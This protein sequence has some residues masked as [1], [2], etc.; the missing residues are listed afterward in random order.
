MSAVLTMLLAGN[1]MAGDGPRPKQPSL[2]RHVLPLLAK[3]GC[4]SGACHGA[5]Q[6]QNG[7]RL[8][9][10]GVDPEQDRTHLLR[11][12]GGRRVDLQNPDNSLF[13]RKALGQMAHE[14]GAR[15]RE[16]TWEHEL[17]R[18]WVQQGL[19]NDET[20]GSG[21]VRLQVTPASTT[22][23]PGETVQ[24]QVEATHADG[25]KEDVTALCTFET[26]V[27]DT[28]AALEGGR[29]EAVQPGLSAV[30]VR[31]GAEPVVAMV[32]VPRPGS[33][34]FP[35]VKGNNFIDEHV[36]A[37]LRR[38]NLPPSEVCDDAT[39]LRR[40]SLDATGTLPTPAEV[41]AFLAD[42][43][44]RK[45]E[46]KIAELLE[47]PGYSALWATKFCDL[48]KIS[49]FDGN[50]AMSEAAEAKRAYDWIRQR[51]KENV[52]YDHLV[53]RILTA[54]SRE[55]REQQE[56][57]KEV[58]RMAEENA[59]RETK[60]SAYL[61]RKTLDLYWQRKEATGIKG[62]LQAAHAFLGLRLECAQC[63]R[64][65][66]DVWKQDD[67]LSFANFFMR[68][69][70]AGYPNAKELNP[71]AAQRLKKAPMEAKALRA[72]VKKLQDRLKSLT[73]KGEKGAI[74]R[75]KEEIAALEVKARAIESGPKRY[76]TE[77]LHQS[78]RS[79]YAS[80]TSPLGTQRSEKFRLL[81]AGKESKPS[82]EQ[83][84]RALVMAWLR[85]RDNPFFARA[86]VNRIWAHYFDRG[87]ID[88]P[89][90][91]SPLNPPS[92]PEL[93]EALAQ[94]FVENG[95][96]LKRLHR[97]ILASRTYQTSSRPT[98][99]NRADRRNFAYY[100]LR[101]PMTEVLIDAVNQATGTVEEYPERLHLAAGTRAL[102]VP[103]PIRVENETASL[104]AAYQAL[105]RPARNPQTLCDCER[106]S[107]ATM[108]SALFIVNH[109]WMHRKI[110]DPQGRLARILKDEAADGERV[111]ELF[112]ATWSRLPTATERATVL[113]H[114]EGSPSRQQ[115]L[116]DLLWVLLNAKEFLFNH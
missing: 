91:L 101:R 90:H 59:R 38:L 106:E 73:K 55:G 111:E 70:G 23:R 39:F 41:R 74:E 20:V 62:A 34:P 99:A 5:V 49:G 27:R 75:C 103:G 51:L 3:L 12:A 4:N 93:L 86:L 68:V 6:G 42:R 37:Q 76:G 29:I 25:T 21:T 52:P 108:V 26:Q 100:Y 64:H 53:E 89:D 13:L 61:D 109:P 71:Q 28:A 77:V 58:D 19:P 72:E 88:P 32:T 114:L 112:L 67:L 8:S 1:G 85:A 110:Q 98:E 47:R 105:G 54:T 57:I 94:D 18:R 24:L 44:P 113:R 81:G 16:G 87:I 97:T 40:A 7:F 45:R 60:L 36:L 35:E 15:I 50:F 107:N 17:L 31:Y 11:D 83:D 115:A 116:E 48:L 33:E 10:F 56:W 66:H 95:Y 63:H 102:E 30:V 46:K 9:L 22:L 65:P 78:G 14:G 43:D 82:K 84:P 80:V 79:N 104:A 69:K 92:H 2:R 96:D